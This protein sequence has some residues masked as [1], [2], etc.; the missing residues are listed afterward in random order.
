MKKIIYFFIFLCL[1]SCQLGKI[2]L[3]NRDLRKL[4]YQ[5][6][7]AI[8]DA[9]YPK[10]LEIDTNLI[11]ISTASELLIW[12]TI[13]NEQYVLMVAWKED[14]SFYRNSVDTIFDTGTRPIWVSASPELKR[15]LHLLNPKDTVLR[16][17]Q[18]LGLPP[19]SKYQYFV[20]FWVRPQDLFRAC[21]DAEITDRQCSTCFPKDVASNHV[22]WIN[23]TRIKSY[24]S[25]S[26]YSQYPWSQLGYTYDWNPHNHTHIGISE[27]VI[28]AN[29]K[30]YVNAIYSNTEYFKK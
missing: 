22:K 11:A 10:P 28:S 25:C 12:K 26:L 7:E 15:R 4:N 24:Y 14:A 23:E 20:E 19:D 13:R 18:L 6:G 1:V 27:F 9:A 3:E 5:Y 16:L 8:A 29:R 21:P 30:I 17:N 2:S